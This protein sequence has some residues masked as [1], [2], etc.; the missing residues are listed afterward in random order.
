MLIASFSANPLIEYI[1]HSNPEDPYQPQLH[2][3]KWLPHASIV[4][5]AVVIY[6]L[7]ALVC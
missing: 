6:C 2:N 1:E 5:N 4:A 3:L 7:L